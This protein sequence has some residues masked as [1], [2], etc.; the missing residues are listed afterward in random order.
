M[1]NILNKLKSKFTK[2][3]KQP[4]RGVS[5]CIMCGSCDFEKLGNDK[6]CKNCGAVF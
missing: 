4:Y 1:K 6:Y 3:K 2:P 5:E